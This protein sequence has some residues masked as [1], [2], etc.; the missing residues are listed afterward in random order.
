MRRFACYDFSMKNMT[1]ASGLALVLL[2][3][4]VLSAQA[5]APSFGGGG[6]F[7]PGSVLG[8]SAVSSGYCAKLS[9]SLA[10]GARDATTS[11]QITE[12]Q[13]FLAAYYHLASVDTV[14]GFFGPTTES[15]V[16][17][18]QKEK[19][20][21]AIGVVGPLTRAAIAS[22]CVKTVTTTTP[23]STITTPPATSTGKSCTLNGTTV[24]DGA[25]VTAYKSSS[26][27]SGKSCTSEKRVCSNGILS[28]SYTY[29]SCSVSAATL[30]FTKTGETVDQ[31]YP[32]HARK[33]GLLVTANSDAT[34]VSEWAML[35]TSS[36]KADLSWGDPTN[37]PDPNASIEEYELKKNCAQG[38]DFLWLNAYRDPAPGHRFPVS[39]TRAE[40]RVGNGAWVDITSGGSC[41]TQGQPYMLSNLVNETYE[42]RVW[43][44]IYDI[45]GAVGRRFFWQERVSSD[46][47]TNACWKNDSTVTRPVITQRETWWDSASGWIAGGSGS[48]GAN[49]EPDGAT[50]SYARGQGIGKGVGPGWTTSGSASYCMQYQWDW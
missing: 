12:L 37:W 45:Y 5:A 31:Y 40:I 24:H 29:A 3:S 32:F 36:T 28:G 44:N 15:N 26:V 11:G 39:T 48:M 8:V 6:W 2:L 30:S 4:S 27:D 14:T 21:S 34:K 16:L 35:P 9:L 19:G 41:G 50:V 20:L 7:T 22:A 18:F 25:T 1:R 49:G 43:G 23:P 42:L 38:L 13:K 46:Q 10:R 33:G 47:T 17:R